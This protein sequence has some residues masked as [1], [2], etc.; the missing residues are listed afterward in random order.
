MN[1]KSL[2]SYPCSLCGVE[3]PSPSHATTAQVCMYREEYRGK[4][5]GLKTGGREG[6]PL[7][8][9]CIKFSVSEKE[10]HRRL[11]HTAS[12]LLDFC[13]QFKILKIAF[14]TSRVH[15]SESV[16]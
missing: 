7:V 15:Y 12:Y 1:K 6:A 11:S 4:V 5:L 3:Q 14:K 8:A 2:Q 13:A 16:K 10:L 9:I